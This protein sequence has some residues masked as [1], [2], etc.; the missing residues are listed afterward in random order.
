MAATMLARPAVTRGQPAA[1]GGVADRPGPARVDD[2]G[3]DAGQPS[4]DDGPATDIDEVD[5]G[6]EGEREGYPHACEDRPRGE[7]AG[8]RN[9]G[10]PEAG[11]R[12]SAAM[13][14]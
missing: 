12:V 9:A 4:D 8:L 13:E 6:E 3:D 14:V 7:Q 5:P 2:G 1:G 10:G 11:G